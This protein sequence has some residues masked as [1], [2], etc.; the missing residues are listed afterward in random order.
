[1]GWWWIGGG[2][3]I[4]TYV[5]LL[6]HGIVKDALLWAA[7]FIED[8]ADR[9]PEA[10]ELPSGMSLSLDLLFKKHHPRIGPGIPK[11]SLEKTASDLREDL[12]EM[13]KWGRTS[14]VEG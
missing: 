8:R 4:L 6:G 2:G 14:R 12:P 9:V 10:T 1:M 11:S 7:L 13:R 5:F 3:E